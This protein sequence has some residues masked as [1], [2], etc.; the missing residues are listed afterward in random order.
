[1]TGDHVACS[2]CERIR[3]GLLAQPV[4]AVSS[5]AFA[6]AAVPI[7]RASGGKRSWRAVAVAAAFA[8]AGSVAYHGPGG[9]L[10]KA[11]HDWSIT[12][13]VATTAGAVARSRSGRVVPAQWSTPALT[14]AVAVALHATSRTGG[15]LCRPDS[16]VQG[17]AGWHVLAAVAL[18]Q[19]AS[20]ALDP[21]PHPPSG[22]TDTPR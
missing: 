11:L 15:P 18:A 20:R 22:G 8:G 14:M 4:N 12:G 21:V 17:H 19:T 6:V 16:L 1:M 7:W 13:L 3:P 9:R 2:D 5:M 10:G